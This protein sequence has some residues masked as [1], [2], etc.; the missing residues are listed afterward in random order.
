MQQSFGTDQ[1]THNHRQY[2]KRQNSPQ[3]KDRQ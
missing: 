2:S 3:Y 1:A